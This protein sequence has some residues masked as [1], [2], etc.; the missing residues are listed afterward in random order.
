[1]GE[2]KLYQD[3]KN[4]PTEDQR[5]LIIAQEIEEAKNRK[6]D[7]SEIATKMDI[8][9]LRSDMKDLEIRVLKAINDQTKFYLAGLAFLGLIFKLAEMFIK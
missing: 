1:M 4:A 2:L 5:L 7:L 9:T 3:L 8:L 6:P